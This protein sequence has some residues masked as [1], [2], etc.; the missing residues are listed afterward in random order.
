METM[1]LKAMPM[2]PRSS[3]PMRLASTPLATNEVNRTLFTMTPA[4]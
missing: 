1:S 2:L 3:K 4:R